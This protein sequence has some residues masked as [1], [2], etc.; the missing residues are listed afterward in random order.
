M[1]AQRG[2]GRKQ[3]CE[4]CRCAGEMDQSSKAG[5]L[6]CVIAILGHM[7]LVCSTVWPSYVS[8]L[9]NHNSVLLKSGRASEVVK[10]GSDCQTVDAVRHTVWEKL[11]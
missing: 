11:S 2:D 10:G 9:L 7:T 4:M 8:E 1:V 6:S 5:G 3:Q